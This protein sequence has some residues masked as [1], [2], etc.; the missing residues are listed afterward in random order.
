MT[1]RRVLGSFLHSLEVLMT[2]RALDKNAFLCIIL[3]MS[4]IE[5]AQKPK[6]YNEQKQDHGDAATQRRSDEDSYWDKKYDNRGIN[7]KDDEQLKAAL[8]EADISYD[9]MT[10]AELSAEADKILEES[11]GAS[12]EDDSNKTM[13]IFPTEAELGITTKKQIRDNLARLA[14]M[15]DDHRKHDDL[16]E[17][18]YGSGIHVINR[19]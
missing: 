13:D 15:D 10:S 2:G 14:T 8:N 17:V 11:Y 5:N 18:N 1:L 16:G 9:S 6:Q 19:S 4:L 3:S 7:R 12:E